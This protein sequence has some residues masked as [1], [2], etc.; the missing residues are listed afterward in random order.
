MGEMYQY[1]FVDGQ[2]IHP[3]ATGIKDLFGD[4]QIC[5]S[6]FDGS[7]QSV[8]K[9]VK[10]LG[11]YVADHGPYDAVMGFSLGAALAAAFLLHERSH[12]VSR[13][14]PPTFGCAI[15][16]CGVLP[17]AGF[18]FRQVEELQSLLGT[19]SAGIAIRTVHAWSPDDTHFPEQSTKLVEICD[20][21]KRMEVKHSSGHSIPSQG[22][23]LK[24]IADAI[25][26]AMNMRGRF[27]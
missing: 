2:Y 26:E 8:L 24:C 23:E 25:E 9:A 12:Q 4:E 16:L 27:S 14:E 19:L 22:D 20:K 10:D 5:Y 21:T 11:E 1:D 18:D 15:F 7:T 6:Y 13:P 17:T 3:P